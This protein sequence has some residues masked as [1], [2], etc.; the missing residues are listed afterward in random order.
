VNLQNV[1]LVIPCSGWKRPRQE[2]DVLQVDMS[3]LLGPEAKALL[4]EGRRLAFERPGTRL[5]LDSPVKSALTYYTGQPYA[6][7]GVKE[8]LIGAIRRGLPCL[9]ISGSYGVV[10]PEEP[11]HNYKAH[12]G[13]QT[14]SVWSPAGDSS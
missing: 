7:T 3:E 10:H 1:L 8:A 12:L 13:T 6:T 5:D 14:K 9:I 4:S 2:L 11:I